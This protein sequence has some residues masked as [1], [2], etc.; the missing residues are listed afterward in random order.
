M[1]ICLFRHDAF[2]RQLA[3]RL[4]YG[5][6]TRLEMFY[7]PEARIFASIGDQGFQASLA[8]RQRKLPQIFFTLE[9]QIEC[10][11]YEIVRRPLG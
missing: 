10:E 9:Q 3:G 1:S 4:Q 11:V 2:E 7:E 6:A 5:V 8:L